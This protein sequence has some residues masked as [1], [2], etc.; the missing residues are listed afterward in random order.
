MSRV[1]AAVGGHRNRT[2][3]PPVTQEAI[4]GRPADRAVT[5]DQLHN[6]GQRRGPRSEAGGPRR[7]GASAETSGSV[8]T[9]PAPGWGSGRGC[10]WCFCRR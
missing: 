7:A 10:D 8:T 4:G 9:A 6:D 3:P 5:A 2:P 1:S